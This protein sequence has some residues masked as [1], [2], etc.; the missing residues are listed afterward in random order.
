MS[1]KIQQV[2]EKIKEAVDDLVN[3]L[4]RNYFRGMQKDMFDCSSRC[5]EDKI[6][7]RSTVDHC[8]EVCNADM[9]RAQMNLEKELKDLQAQ[10]SRC[11][12]TAY[13]KLIQNYGPNPNLYK[14][15]QLTKFTDN[16]D[17][18]VINCANDHIQLLPKI[19]ERYINFLNKSKWS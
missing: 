9:K 4:E 2:Q 18:G 5:C 11:T 15:D 16:L 12:M 6:A 17:K 1:Q 3:D 13:D 7:A 10:L 8:V 19:K 14:E